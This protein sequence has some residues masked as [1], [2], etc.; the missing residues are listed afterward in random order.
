MA[1][2]VIRPSSMPESAQSLQNAVTILR[3]GKVFGGRKETS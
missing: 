1:A 2:T 3:K